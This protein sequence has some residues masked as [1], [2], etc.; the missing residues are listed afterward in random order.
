MSRVSLEAFSGIVGHVYD[1]VF[2]TGAWR[3]AALAAADQIGATSAVMFTPYFGPPRGG[4]WEATNIDPSE[5][6]KYPE[7]YVHQ[8]LWM[9][10]FYQQHRP[11]GR[12]V[13]GQELVEPAV[14]RK[15]EFFND[16]LRPVDVEH[17]TSILFRPF[18]VPESQ[19]H[20]SLFRAPGRDA[21][22][23]RE[24]AFLQLVGPHISRAWSMK[25]A[26]AGKDL[27]EQAADAALDQF[28]KGVLLLDRQARILFANAAARRMIG[29][30]DGLYSVDGNLRA[31]SRATDTGLQT[32]LAGALRGNIGAL[33]SDCIAVPR[34]SGLRPYFVTA[35]PVQRPTILLGT[36]HTAAVV[37]VRDPE[38]KRRVSIRAL[39]K[40]LD[41]TEAEARLVAALAEGATV[42]GYAARAKVSTNTARWHLKRAMHKAGC[43]SQVEL[44]ALALQFGHIAPAPKPTNG[45]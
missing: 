7:H 41:F 36:L 39:R 22:D 45:S 33:E 2:D 30:R 44:V 31:S 9:S 13:L 5:L 19:L 20:L 29:A 8:D 16:F 18:A 14:M 26:L 15:S 24:R 38:A 27:R 40:A 17:I 11:F 3:R 34:P 10:A 43:G 1:G 21:F 42:T 28:D 4:L 23:E 12:S 32:L 37:V 25:L 6:V 35:V